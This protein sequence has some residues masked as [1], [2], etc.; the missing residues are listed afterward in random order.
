MH[1]IKPSKDFVEIQ[2]G[3]LALICI[4]LFVYLYVLHAL[5]SKSVILY[6]LLQRTH[7]QFYLF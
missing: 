1:R 2:L 5:K 7:F 6:I 4:L 3:R